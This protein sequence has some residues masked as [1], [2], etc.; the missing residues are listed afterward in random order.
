MTQFRSKLW[1]WKVRV[2]LARWWPH[3]D[4]GCGMGWS[5]EDLSSGE[6]PIKLGI[7][8]RTGTFFLSRAMWASMGAKAGWMSQEEADE[9][10]E[11]DTKGSTHA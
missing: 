1:W 4:Q 3:P 7:D 10:W 2:L 5:G 8:G 11:E 6:L 9:I